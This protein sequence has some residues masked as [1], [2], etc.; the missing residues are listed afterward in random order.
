MEAAKNSMWILARNLVAELVD[1]ELL[2]SG[3]GRDRLGRNM[4]EKEV[5]D[6]QKR[7]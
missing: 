2:G 7:K 6:Q 3:A 5:L 4:V 1:E